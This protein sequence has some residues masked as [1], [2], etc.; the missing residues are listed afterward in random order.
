MLQTNINC[1]PFFLSLLA[2]QSSTSPFFPMSGVRNGIIT[3]KSELK[4]KER[5]SDN[6][7]IEQEI[8]RFH[9]ATEIEIKI[10]ERS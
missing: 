2:S 5:F 4:N 6:K 1:A 10:L 3:I 9:Y 7:R 8:E